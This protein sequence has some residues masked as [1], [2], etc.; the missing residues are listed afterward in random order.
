MVTLLE[1][2]LSLDGDTVLNM[3]LGLSL[4]LGIVLLLL[5]DTSGFNHVGFES[6]IAE[7]SHK[8]QNGFMEDARLLC[9]EDN[10]QFIVL[11]CH[12]TKG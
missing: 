3:L 12:S 4:I 1:P 9:G 10:R 5:V 2:L 11:K 8:I 6:I 7:L